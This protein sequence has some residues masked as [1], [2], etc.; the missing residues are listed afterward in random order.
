MAR[1][2]LSTKQWNMVAPILSPQNAKRG[3]GRPPINDRDCLEGILWI[4]RVGA[5]WRDLPKAFGNWERVYAR[6]RLWKNNGAFDQVVDSI[7]G[8]LNLTTVQIDGT[9]AKA[10]QHAAGARRNGLTPEES[11][12]AQG[13]GV[14]RGGRTSKVVALVDNEGNLVRF[15]LTPG[16]AAEVKELLGLLEG[17]LTSELIGDKAYDSQ[18]IRDALAQLNIKA[19]IPPRSNRKAPIAYDEA[20]YKLRHKVEN[21]FAHLKQ[22]RGIATRYCKLGDSFVAFIQ[23]ASWML[24]TK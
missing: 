12:Q 6:F 2:Y 24:I 23:L 16:N 1:R 15:S 17:I 22:N 9:F 19:T 11:A 18:E 5:P 3:R 20:S 10:H 21:F 7:F 13:I 4:I 14:S 8:K